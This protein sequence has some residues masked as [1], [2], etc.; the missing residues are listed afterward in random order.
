M[1]LICINICPLKRSC[2]NVSDDVDTAGLVFPVEPGHCH[3][4]SLSYEELCWRTVCLTTLPEQFLYDN[5]PFCQQS[6]LCLP[7]S[8]VHA[9]LPLIDSRKIQLPICLFI[10]YT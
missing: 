4:S 7:S 2:V 8:L 10:S 3:C 1:T 6:L 5:V 9:N